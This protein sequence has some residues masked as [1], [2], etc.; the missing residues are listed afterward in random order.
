M[1][2]PSVTSHLTQVSAGS[3]LLGGP[4]GFGMLGGL[5][6]VS[7]PFQFPSL[8]NF[9][10]PGAPGVSGLGTGANSGYSLSQS[11]LMDANQSQGA[12]MKR[13]SH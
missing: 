7:L 4:L 12:D 5:V 10:P 6:P 9:T 8:L 2:T 13:K 3:P 1:A 11:D